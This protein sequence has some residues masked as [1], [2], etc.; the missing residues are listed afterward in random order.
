MDLFASPYFL[1]ILFL[2]GACIFFLV[3]FFSSWYAQRPRRFW[4]ARLTY[5]DDKDQQGFV[6]L[7]W[8]AAWFFAIIGSLLVAFN[9]PLIPRAPYDIILQTV[10][11]ILL[12]WLISKAIVAACIFLQRIW[13]VLI[14]VNNWIFHGKPLFPKYEKLRPLKR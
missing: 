3:V 14:R 13:F 6:R 1:G 10:Y 4:L 12:V 11:G 2:S 8:V 9:H 7:S 5:E